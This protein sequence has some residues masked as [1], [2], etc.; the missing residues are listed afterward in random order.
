MLQPEHPLK[1]L[2]KY[3]EEF[4]LFVKVVQ[5]GGFSHAAAALGLARE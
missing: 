3:I 2:M 4:Y 5:E 1:Q